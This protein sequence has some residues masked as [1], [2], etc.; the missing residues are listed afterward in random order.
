MENQEKRILKGFEIVEAE[1]R[2]GN[3]FYKLV[4]KTQK[5]KECALFLSE[6]QKEVID[7]VGVE[8]CW[9][10]IETRKSS[11]NKIYNVIALHVADEEVFDFFVKDRAFITLAKL[12]A[13][14]A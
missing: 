12:H 3:V 10:D 11:E 6:N 4:V 1:S 2:T 13:K 7:L 5:D 14:N 9:V 8:N